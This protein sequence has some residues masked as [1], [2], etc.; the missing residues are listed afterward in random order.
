MKTSKII[1]AVLAFSACVTSAWA[2]DPAASYPNR[3]IRFIVPY[4]PGA[5]TDVLGR[6]IGDRLSAALKQPVIVENR[7]GAGTLIGADLVAK[8]PGDGYTLHVEAGFLLEHLHEEV[9]RAATAGG[10]VVELAGVLLHE[11]DQF[12]DRL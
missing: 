4:P 12:G 9:V 1:A 7:A 8:A 5:L 11:V 10:G 2:Q 3:P 6:V